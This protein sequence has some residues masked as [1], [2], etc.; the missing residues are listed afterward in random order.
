MSRIL[1]LDPKKRATILWEKFTRSQPL[2]LSEASLAEE[3]KDSQDQFG[4]F[5]GNLLSIR[6][7]GDPAVTL[8]LKN[9]CVMGFLSSEQYAHVVLSVILGLPRHILLQ[10]SSIR[11]YVLQASR[12]RLEDC[13]KNA[14]ILLASMA[15]AGDS[16]ALVSCGVL[17]FPVTT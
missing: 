4:R 11:S 16:G 10:E 1:N 2:T 13:R 12:S 5:I 15:A 7:G 3:L 14:E 6:E 9:E 8:L 17:A